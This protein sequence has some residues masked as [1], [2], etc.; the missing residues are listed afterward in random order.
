LQQTQLVALGLLRTR[1]TPFPD[2]RN[3]EIVRKLSSEIYSHRHT[4]NRT[5]ARDYL[6]L[7]QV[8]DAESAGIDPSLWD[9][10]CSYRDL[11]SFEVP[12]TPDEELEASDDDERTWP[13]LASVCIESENRID[14]RLADVRVRRL[15]Q[16]PPQVALNLQ[17]GAIAPP[18]I[19]IPDLPSGLDPAEIARLVREIVQP[20]IQATIEPLIERATNDAVDQFRKS[21]PSRGF[22]RMLVNRRWV[23]GE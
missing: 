2:T 13:S 12:F 19:N 1:S 10:Y 21:L 11:F 3:Q 14:L 6:G 16:I 17:L 15:R 5:E 18:P 20:A 7:D 8:V 4:I 9:L 23:S 22:E